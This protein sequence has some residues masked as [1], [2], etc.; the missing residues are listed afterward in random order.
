MVYWRLGWKSD[1]K[2]HNNE[3]VV[4]YTM[5]KFTNLFDTYTTFD[6]FLFESPF[7]ED[8][9]NIL[10]ILNGGG[11]C[12]SMKHYCVM[13]LKSSVTP[14]PLFTGPLTVL[15]LRI[16][17]TLNWPTPRVN[18]DRT[19]T[20]SRTNGGPDPP[21][22]PHPLHQCVY[23]RVV[24]YEGLTDIGEGPKPERVYPVIEVLL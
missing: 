19:N 18:Y 11:N 20:W 13:I 2:T 23:V 10:V 16:P 4:E 3:E 7:Y 22:L 9:Y 1:E 12:F 17:E 21:P 6:N 8:T 15:P 14:L 5:M 24:D